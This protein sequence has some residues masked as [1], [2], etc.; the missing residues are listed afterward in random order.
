MYKRQHDGDAL[1][2]STETTPW[3]PAVLARGPK[4]TVPDIKSVY[5]TSFHGSGVTTDP[6]L[7]QSLLRPDMGYTAGQILDCNACHDPHGTINPFALQQK[8]VSANGGKTVD[9]MMVYKNTTGTGGYDLRFFCAT[10]HVFDPATRIVHDSLA[11]TSTA[12][13]P[14]NCTNCHRHIKGTWQ[15]SLL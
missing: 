3:A 12:T 5:S 2:T 1:P 14:S 13:F 11:G 15:N 6:V 4:T 10:C 9:G 8:V 7:T